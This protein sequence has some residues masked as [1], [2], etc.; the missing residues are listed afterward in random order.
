MATMVGNQDSLI[1]LLKQLTELEYDAIEAYKVAVDRLEDVGGKRQLGT[2]MADHQRHVQELS[3]QLRT[4]GVEAP[5][6][7]DMKQVL[8]KG[9]VFLGALLGD[10]AI[11]GAM[12]TNEDDTNTAYERAAART[13]VP[14]HLH[15]IFESHLA[16]ERRHRQWIESWLAQGAAQ[17]TA[18]R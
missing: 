12:K 10:R 18:P 9:K 11:F 5:D 15:A 16:D 13:D 6:G 3:R 7:P 8:T 14:T 2:F 1:G 4:L 17:R